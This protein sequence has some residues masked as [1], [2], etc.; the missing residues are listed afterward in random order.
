MALNSTLIKIV[1]VSI[2][3]TTVV[4]AI[5]RFTL[6]LDED[7]DAIGITQTAAYL[8]LFFSSITGFSSATFLFLRLLDGAG[9]LEVVGLVVVFLALL[10]ALFTFLYTV[11]ALLTDYG[12]EL[13][14]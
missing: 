13:D 2:L 7:D 10:L 1:E 4:F 12:E 5:T 14:L 3:L 8:S 9:T 6:T 11:M